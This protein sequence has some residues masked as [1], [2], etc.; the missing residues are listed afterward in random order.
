VGLERRALSL[1]R[2]IEEPPERKLILTAVGIHCSDHAK[3]GTAAAVAES[4][5]FVCGLKATG[6]V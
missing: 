3:F 1:V 4:V 6:L 2:I 5:Y